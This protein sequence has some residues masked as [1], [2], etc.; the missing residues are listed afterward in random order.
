MKT[1]ERA[2]L[3]TGGAVFV[4]ALLYCGYTFVAVWNR[5]APFD[6]SGDLDGRGPLYGL[7]RSP[8]RVCARPREALA[9][10]RGSGTSAAVGLRLGSRASCSS[11]S[12]RRGSLSA[13]RSTDARGWPAM[14]LAAVQVAGVLII[15]S[16]VRAIDALDLAG[17]RPHPAADALQ[18][19]GPYRWVR[20][21]LYLGWLLATFG[22]AHM[23]GDRLMFAGISLFYLLIAMPFEERSLIAELRGAVPPIPPT[24][25]LA[26]RA[27]RVLK[28]VTGTEGGGS[29]AGDWRAGLARSR[30]LTATA[31]C[32]LPLPTA[33]C[34]LPTADCRLPTADCRLPTADCRLPT[35]DC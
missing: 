1:L 21:P 28:G 17:I 25:T 12:A 4:G 16:A 7:R 3:W 8:Q 11:P 29:G 13:A 14:A 22:P 2:I 24:R 9:G 26:D 30:L 15:A 35:A 6:A 34:R 33:D 5:P 32:R 20:H 10:T 19:R 23:T 18:F 31:D 27:L